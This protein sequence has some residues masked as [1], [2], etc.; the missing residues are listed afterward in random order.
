MTTAQGLF[1]LAGLIAGWAYAQ[2]QVVAMF[3]RKGRSKLLGHCVGALLSWLGALAGFMVFASLGGLEDGT[4]AGLRVTMFIFG[5]LAFSPFVYLSRIAKTK[6]T[7]TT[8]PSEARQEP[9]HA[10]SAELLGGLRSIVQSCAYTLRE[11]VQ[12]SNA[13]EPKKVAVGNAESSKKQPAI[14]APLL[15]ANLVFDYIDRDGVIT[16]RSVRSCRIE[17]SDSHHYLTGYCEERCAER[18]FRFD[19]ISGRLRVKGSGHHFSV[20]ELLARNPT[21]ARLVFD[22]S[23]FRKH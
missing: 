13:A 6:R 11:L 12:S 3:L 19:R 2:F 5:L 10:M 16:S 22:R 4:P 1:V 23:H 8:K 17:A 14:T 21:S 18:T 15:P 7:Y 20:Q 9:A